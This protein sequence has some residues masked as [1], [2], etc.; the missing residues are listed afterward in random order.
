MH[1][2]PH[3]PIKGLV[4][5]WPQVEVSDDSLDDPGVGLGWP[6]PHCFQFKLMYHV[7]SQKSE[8]INFLNS[9]IA[10]VGSYF[11]KRKTLRGHVITP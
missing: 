9:D 8:Q 2:A 4:G 11:Q 10:R 1:D 5:G 7:L 6:L 3:Q